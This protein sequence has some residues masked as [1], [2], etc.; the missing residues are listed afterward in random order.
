MTNRE[1]AA[2]LRLCGSVRTC[3][4]C[5]KCPF[6]RGD[7]PTLCVPKMTAAC[8]NAL[9]NHE[10]HVA[11]LQK[12]IET[13]RGQLEVERR[14]QWVSVSERLPKECED[15]LVLVSGLHNKTVFERSP[16]LGVWFGNRGWFVDEYPLWSSPGV[17]HWMPLPEAPK[18]DA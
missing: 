13:L 18:E 5:L 14:P 16:M 1:L 4:E 10:S 2:A 11:A 6:Y 3:D 9:E 7:D 17:T 12:E 15:V 8:A